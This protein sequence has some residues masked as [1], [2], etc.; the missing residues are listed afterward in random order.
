MSSAEIVELFVIVGSRLD[1]L[2]EFFVT[3]HLAVAAA[4]LGI[5]RLSKPR[6]C[7]Y[8]LL[9]V[10]YL[11]FSWIN[12]RAKLA[13]YQLLVSVEQ[14]AASILSGAQLENLHRLFLESEFDDRT[15]IA[16]TVHVATIVFIV[17]LGFEKQ[18][19]QKAADTAAMKKA[20]SPI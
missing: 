1:A 14:E 6:T 19:R 17:I 18:A 9:S 13:A 16:Y 12:L 15:A 4:V 7:E 3:V 10:A 5:E 11:A 20:G 8:T 2:W